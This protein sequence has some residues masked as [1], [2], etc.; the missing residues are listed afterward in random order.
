MKNALHRTCEREKRESRFD[1]NGALISQGVKFHV[2]F[3]D[4][5]IVK[6]KVADVII[7]ESYKEYN[8]ESLHMDK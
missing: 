7:V 5:V 6:D 2:S 1:R 4:D 3:K 8:R